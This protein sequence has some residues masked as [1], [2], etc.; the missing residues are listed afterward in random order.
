MIDI[1]AQKLNGPIGLDLFDRLLC[2]LPEE[3]ADHIRR[4]VEYNDSLRALFSSLLCRSIIC[5]SLDIENKDIVFSP[6]EYGKPFLKSDPDFHFSVAHAGDWVVCAI[7]DRPVGIDIEKIRP[8]EPDIAGR[9]F[10]TEEYQDLNSKDAIDQQDFFFA[11]WTLKESYTK[12]IGR[13]L[14]KDMQSFTV[15]IPED[16]IYVKNP[17]RDKNIFFRQYGIDP[18][19]KTSVCGYSCE[20]ADRVT[21]MMLDEVTGIVS[22]ERLI[23]SEV[24]ERS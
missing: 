24:L 15:K 19:Y 1:F 11:L 7:N 10:S 3:R 4:F 18:A 21:L 14:Y 12:A 2:L 8:M 16:S 20:F 9:S 17:L 5:K 23:T 6:N 13:G 22:R